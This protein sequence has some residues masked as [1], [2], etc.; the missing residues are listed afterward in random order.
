MKK[1]LIFLLLLLFPSLCFAG[2]SGSSPTWTSTADYTSLKG[3][4]DSATEGDTINV[5]AG[6]KAGTS[7]QKLTI[8]KG[9]RIIGAT[10]GCPDACNGG[11]T[12]TG[13]GSS[14]LINITVSGDKFIEISG[15]TLD[16]N[17]VNPAGGGVGTINNT[18]I[19][20]PLTN[21]RIHHNEFKNSGTHYG[22]FWIYGLVYGLIDH[23]KFTSNVVDIRMSTGT[24]GLANESSIWTNYPPVANWGSANYMYIEDNIGTDESYYVLTSG[25]AS[26]FVYRFNTI[27]LTN[28]NSGFIDI[29]GSEYNRAVVACEVYQNT[30]NKGAEKLSTLSRFFDYR[31]GSALLWYNSMMGTGSMNPYI[32]LRNTGGTYTG[33]PAGGD[34][35][36]DGYLWNN[37]NPS[38]STLAYQDHHIPNEYDVNNY[39]TDGTAYWS[40]ARDGGV[41]KKTSD[42]I[43]MVN[44]D[45]LANRSTLDASPKEGDVYWATD[46]GTW[47]DAPDNSYQGYGKGSGLLYQYT[48]DV[49]NVI[50]TPYAYPH[51]LQEFTENQDENY[52]LTVTKTGAGGGTITSAG[53]SGSINCGDTCQSNFT[54]NDVVTL[55]ATATGSDIF[56]GWSGE[57]CSGTGTCEVTMSQARNVLAEFQHSYVKSKA[58]YDDS[59]F[60]IV[61]QQ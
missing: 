15:L 61:S 20:A 11:T 18:N 28:A 29:H 37:T 48:S 2:Y 6:S 9:I 42:D 52:Y 14:Q 46:Q 31:G 50:Y 16:A 33:G 1:Y 21:L 36:Q 60:K 26:R 49:W 56:I 54:N 58:V 32:S 24:S 23:N 51:P 5:S 4:Y 43:Y 45:I 57:G 12:I 39:F 40:D 59:G 3:A 13:S 22:V 35:V 19:A 10:T 30:I 47:N 7:T 41:V 34:L 27:T 44:Y 17:H 53:G 25:E 38:R 8:T 55:T